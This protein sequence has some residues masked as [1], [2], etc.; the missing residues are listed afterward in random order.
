MAMASFTEDEAQIRVEFDRVRGVFRHLQQVH[1]FGK[2]WFDTLSMGMSGDYKIALEAG[3]TMGRIGS[4]L[5]GA[6]G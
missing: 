4:L 3:S 5:F 6:R 1:F 2:P